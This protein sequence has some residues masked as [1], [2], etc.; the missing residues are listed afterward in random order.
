MIRAVLIAAGALTLLAGAA[1][2]AAEPGPVLPVEH[3]A[4]LDRV[5]Y[6]IGRCYDPAQPAEQRPEQILYNCDGTGTMREMTWSQ[7][8]T[9]G[10]RGTGIDESVEC[11]PDCAEGTHL[12][13]PI[14]VHA[15][16]PRPADDDRCPADVQFYSD[17]TIAYPEG[18]P[19]WIVPGTAWDDGTDFVTVD[20]MPAVHFSDQKPFSCVPLIAE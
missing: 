12:T 5:S 15:W 10:A 1:P 3:T 9:A 20:G 4:D 11:H 7:W 2:A 8:D 14:V 16:N 18:V 17:I 6:L 19:P 13:N